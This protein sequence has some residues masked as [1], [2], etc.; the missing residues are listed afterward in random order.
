[1]EAISNKKAR[2][3]ILIVED[4]KEMQAYLTKKFK[5]DYNV[6]IANNGKEGVEIAFREIPELIVCDLMM[7]VMDGLEVVESIRKNFNTSHIPLILLTANSSEE[8]R[9]KGLETGADD[10]ITKPFN[11]KLLKIK[12]DNLISRRKKLFGNFG[13]EPELPANVLTHSEH[14]KNFI[15]K[16]SIIIEENIGKADFSVD[17]VS[18]RSGCSRTGFY[19]KIKGITGETPHAFINTIQMKKAALLLRETNYSI[20][21]ISLMV[22]YNNTNYF[23]KNFKKHFGNTPKSWQ[24][25]ARKHKENK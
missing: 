1:M 22:G 21:D 20:P 10:Y 11:F 6:F 2:D 18:A 7:P 4:N 25:E 12:I 17:F 13:K 15:E 24:I 23:T 19:K 5:T 16:V 14:D 8:N 3:A 9:V